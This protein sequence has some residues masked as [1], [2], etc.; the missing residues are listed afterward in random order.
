MNLFHRSMETGSCIKFAEGLKVPIELAQKMGWGKELVA[1]T[2]EFSARLKE[3]SIDKVEFCILNGIVL[4][5]PGKISSML[6][7]YTFPLSVNSQ[8]LPHCNAVLVAV[9]LC[10][11]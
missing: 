4:T 10:K 5:Y 7:D 11:Q 2:V 3:L 9:L 8:Y 6:R 1:A